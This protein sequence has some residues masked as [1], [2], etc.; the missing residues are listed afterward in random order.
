MFTDWFQAFFNCLHW[1]RIVSLFY[2]A[3][4][5]LFGSL[6]LLWWSYVGGKKWYNIYHHVCQP[7]SASSIFLLSSWTLLIYCRNYSKVSKAIETLSAG[8][9]GFGEHLPL[10]W[11]FIQIWSKLSTILKCVWVITW[12][13]NISCSKH[14]ENP[15]KILWHCRHHLQTV[16][17]IICIEG[18]ELFI[19]LNFSC[20]SI[21]LH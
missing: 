16:V 2:F 6:V 19:L 13:R 5:L 4:S 17:L 18:K 14:R 8:Y 7:T 20:A 3:L 15:F 12:N 1:F 9:I 21:W 11:I 10:R